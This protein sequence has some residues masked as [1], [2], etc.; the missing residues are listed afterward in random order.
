M[1]ALSPFCLAMA[2]CKP[3][4][5]QFGQA[6]LALWTGY[7]LRWWLGPPGPCTGFNRAKRDATKWCDAVIDGI[8][9]GQRPATASPQGDELPSGALD[10]FAHRR[11]ISRSP[12]SAAMAVRHWAQLSGLP[13]L[14]EMI[15]RFLGS[16]GESR[17][18][19]DIAQALCSVHRTACSPLTD[20]GDWDAGGVRLG[21]CYRA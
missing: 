8:A 9:Y 12:E 18:G 5:A 3:F 21:M 20:A 11:H 7:V 1:H 6:T 4:C 10:D 17:Y 16:V 19:I 2:N 15:E 14:S 13:W